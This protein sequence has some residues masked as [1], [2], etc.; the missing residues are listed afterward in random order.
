MEQPGYIHSKRKVN[1]DKTERLFSLLLGSN[2]LTGGKGRPGILRLLASGYLLYR[3]FT[4]HCPLYA[5][6]SRP[7]LPDTEKNIN[8]RTTV[9][10]NKSRQEVYAFWRRLENLPLFMQHLKSVHTDNND[11]SEWTARIPGGLGSISWRAQIVNEVPGEVLG[12]SSLPGSQI[13]NAGKVEFRDTAD[14]G[15]ELRVIITYRAPLGDIGTRI[16]NMFTPLFEKMV[17]NDV[18][19][20]KIYIEKSRVPFVSGDT[21]TQ[22]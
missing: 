15:T 19:N 8:I 9:Q 12:W 5:A 22:L 13:E 17:H 11:I 21:S 1:V 6:I 4:G 18:E 14:G 20:Y 7:G 10:V 16:A 3:G 2:V